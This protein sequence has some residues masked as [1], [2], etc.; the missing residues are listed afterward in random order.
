MSPDDLYR[1]EQTISA[2]NAGNLDPEGH[3]HACIL[4]LGFSGQRNPVGSAVLHLLE[5]PTHPNRMLAV[6]HLA[7]TL[8]KR[9]ICAGRDSVDIAGDAL[10]WYAFKGCPDCTGRGV[11]N[12]EQQICK[13]CGGTGERKRPSNKVTAQAV[14]IVEEALRWL[15]MQE[16]A[17]LRK[18]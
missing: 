5:S 8:E 2:I 1:V 11:I 6:Y 3:A 13:R 14:S 15:E 18:A 4:A 10:A 16:R 17:Q 12:L 9:S 7:R